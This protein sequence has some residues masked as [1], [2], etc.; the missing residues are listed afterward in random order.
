MTATGN[1]Y[2][3][4]LS[5]YIMEQ[6]RLHAESR[7]TFTALLN[8]VATACKRLSNLVRLGELAGVLGAAGVEN[9]QGEDQKKLDVIANEVFIDAMQRSGPLHL[10]RW[11][12]ITPSHHSMRLA[13][14]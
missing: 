5:Q 13:I 8:D 3:T 1:A 6:G 7:G 14:T 9:V 12:A 10:K 11:T 4:T 2:G